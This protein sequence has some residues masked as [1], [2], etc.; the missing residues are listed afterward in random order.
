MAE[1]RS[2]FDLSGLTALVTGASKGIGSGCAIAL[3]KSGDDLVLAARNANDLETIADAIC[4]L[5]RNVNGFA[6]YLHRRLGIG[7][8]VHRTCAPML[9]VELTI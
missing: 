7:I 1:T 3:A 8:Q 4:Q 5:G 6:A 2:P 9:E